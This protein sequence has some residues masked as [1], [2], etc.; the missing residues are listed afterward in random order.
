MEPT[1]LLNQGTFGCIYS[2]E[3]PCGSSK[4]TTV[5]NKYSP[6]FL[7][8]IQITEE[9]EIENNLGKQISN[10]PNYKNFFAPATTLCNVDIGVINDEE[11]SKCKV[12]SDTNKKFTSSRIRYVGSLNLAKFLKK[13]KDDDVLLIKKIIETN[14][15]IQHSLKLLY[16]NDVIHYDLKSNNIMMDDKYGVPI[17][18]DFGL[19][20]NIKQLSSNYKEFYVFYDKHPYWSIE[21]MLLSYFTNAHKHNK[22]QF[23]NPLDKEVVLDI[24]ESY[25]N[26]NEIFEAVFFRIEETQTYKETIINFIESTMTDRPL[27]T[28]KEFMDLLI[29]T[30]SSSWD[31]FAVAVMYMFILES[32]NKLESQLG[33]S[34]SKSTPYH[35]YNSL[36]KQIILS[37]PTRPSFDEITTIL[38][39]I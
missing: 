16:E 13:Y 24:I 35:K 27:I 10:I 36:I 1:K 30:S 34:D 23:E 39:N 38:K 31:T 37:F 8:K 22:I 29:E 9:G 3:I 26:K 6:V 2:P 25:I 33:D 20:F 4:Q 28:I 11:I 12:L 32:A 18:I 15:Y 5:K 14:L 21:I 7:S 17:I 19:S